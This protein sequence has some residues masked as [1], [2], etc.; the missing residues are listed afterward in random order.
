MV[1]EALERN[2]PN[3]ILTR[4]TGLL[5]LID[6][7]HEIDDFYEGTERVDE[8]LHWGSGSHAVLQAF[9]K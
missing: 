4:K 2:F 3:K 8:V 5:D 6:N 1:T 7:V 9:T